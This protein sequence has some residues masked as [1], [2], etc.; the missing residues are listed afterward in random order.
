MLASLGHDDI[1][2]SVREKFCS[3]PESEE[4]S[5]PAN[6]SLREKVQHFKDVLSL[7][8]PPPPPSPVLRWRV[9]SVSQTTPPSFSRR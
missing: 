3:P 9:I 8:Y 6:Q 5:K 2:K 4:V 7:S 1:A